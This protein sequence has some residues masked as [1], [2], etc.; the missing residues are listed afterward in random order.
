MIR[1]HTETLVDWSARV[2]P[3][4]R[5]AVSVA[6]DSHNLPSGE[7]S[8]RPPR[9]RANPVRRATD[10]PQPAGPGCPALVRGRPGG[11]VRRRGSPIASRLDT[12][13]GARTA[14]EL[15]NGMNRGITRPTDAVLFDGKMAGT[16]HVA[17]GRAYGAP[18][19]G[20]N[21]STVH[22]DHS[23]QMCR[24]S[25]NEVDG[26]PIQVDGEMSL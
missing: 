7:V 8:S 18:D 23:T 10:R 24:G 25:R 17:L 14:G 2:S 9:S 12:D 20:G 11:R 3:G 16:V 21:D 5:I 4:D 13:P 1:S 19:C 6:S 22:V 26:E 15:G